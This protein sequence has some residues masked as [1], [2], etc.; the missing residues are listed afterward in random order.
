MTW[1]WAP[2]SG[3]NNERQQSDTVGQNKAEVPLQKWADLSATDDSYGVSIINDCKYGMDKYNDSTL[4]LTLIYTPENDY[5][6]GSD[7]Q[8]WADENYGPA[9]MTVQDHGENRFAYAIY[10]HAGDAGASDV[11]LEAEAFNQPMNAF[12][13]TPTREALARITALVPSATIRYWCGR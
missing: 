8:A 3:G 5:D 7:T 12:R 11:Q 1:G 4:R 9:G 10:G 2:S 13:P 6:H